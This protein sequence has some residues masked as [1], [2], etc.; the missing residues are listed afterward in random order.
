V[1]RLLRGLLTRSVRIPAYAIVSTDG[2]D[3][4]RMADQ[5][6]PTHTIR[7]GHSYS[8]RCDLGSARNATTNKHPDHR[9]RTMS[10]HN[11][12]NKPGRDRAA[13]STII[14]EDRTANVYV[15]GVTSF[16]MEIP[17][18]QRGEKAGS[19]FRGAQAIERESQLRRVVGN[20]VVRRNIIVGNGFG[21]ALLN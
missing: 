14:S 16:P 7:R 1:M 9:S 15:F 10:P 20:W 8:R 19:G 18:A 21:V 2:I 3:F 13:Y 4:R 12:P 6:L 5:P 11:P 17:S